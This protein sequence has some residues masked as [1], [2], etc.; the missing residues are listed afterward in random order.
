MIVGLKQKLGFWPQSLI[1]IWQ[2]KSDWIWF[3]AVSVGEI[4][5]ALPLLLKIKEEKPNNPIMLSTTTK[6]GYELAEKIGKEK[7]VT[8][9]FF[10]FDFPNV[11]NNLLNTVKVKLLVITETEIW[12]NLL[13]EC[14]KREI[15]TV[16]I[17][18]RLSDKS[19]KN[20]FALR[21]FFNQVINL[22]TEVISQSESDTYKF[23]L[24]G[25]E[26]KKIKTFG[27]LKFVVSDEIN[28]PSTINHQPLTI[29]FASTHR[30]E[31]E[32]AINTYK[33]LRNRFKDIKIVIA[34]RHIDRTEEIKQLIEKNGFKAVLKTENKD[35]KDEVLILNTIG[36]LQD[37]YTSCEITVLC[38]TF[39]E[40]GGHNILEPIRAGSYTIIGPNDF[41]IKALT[42]PF[43]ERDALVQV[44]T[45]GELVE[46]I[47][48]AITNPDL[49]KKKI[50]NGIK[51]IKENQNVLNDTKDRLLSYL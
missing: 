24:L 9:L 28:Q 2:S 20:Y 38:G 37:F 27:N 6:A 41:K 30:G 22:F 44:K 47:S 14:K 51:L 3:H 48:E 33:E 10:P 46:K 5:A 40:I 21:I 32:I 26:E 49:R 17:N 23:R 11:V 8:V 36:D 50:E 45:T 25:L 7:G 39:A 18:A 19:F 1:K 43:I 4:N 16:L 34:P 31:D 35:I 42:K 15:P 12:P 13:K 29:I